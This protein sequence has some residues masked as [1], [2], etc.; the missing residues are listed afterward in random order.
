MSKRNTTIRIRRVYVEDDK[1][2]GSSGSS[3]D[4]DS[5]KAGKN[6]VK[7]EK[8]KVEKTGKVKAESPKIRQAT[9]EFSQKI[10][11]LEWVEDDDAPLFESRK[12]RKVRKKTEKHWNQALENVAKPRE[13]G[14]ESHPEIENEDVQRRINEYLGQRKITKAVGVRAGYQPTCDQTILLETCIKPLI[15]FH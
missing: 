11:E 10:R 7:A 14:E 15:S 2:P 1:L 6:K 13:R 4:E 9:E 8:V 12:D 5:Q 3:S